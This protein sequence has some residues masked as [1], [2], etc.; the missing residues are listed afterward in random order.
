[1]KS[2]VHPSDDGGI[3]FLVDE[4]DKLRRQVA[5]LQRIR[6]APNTYVE[7]KDCCA[8][9]TFRAELTGPT[10]GTFSAGAFGNLE[11]TWSSGFGNFHTPGVSLTGGDEFSVVEGL[12]I[13]TFELTVDATGTVPTS[14]AF[15][16][17][18]GGYSNGAG[19]SHAEMSVTS[20]HLSHAET[21]YFS[22]DNTVDG[23]L[24]STGFV[25]N[26]SNGFNQPVVVGGH[27]AGTQ[28][29]VLDP[30]LT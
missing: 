25:V 17:S 7:P 8:G 24:T 2:S 26:F 30:T 16:V 11:W 21:L 27:F 19:I 18:I 12:W 29:P 4:I 6:N 5:D 23:P 15:E 28:V 20:P 10:G 22:D 9:E 3:K 13:F 1:M 14:G